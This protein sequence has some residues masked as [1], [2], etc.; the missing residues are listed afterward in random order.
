MYFGALARKNAF[1]I[2]DSTNQAI[3]RRNKKIRENGKRIIKTKIKKPAMAKK[4]IE[5]KIDN[6]VSISLNKK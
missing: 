5:F 4:A 6:M 1:T 3:A 2:D